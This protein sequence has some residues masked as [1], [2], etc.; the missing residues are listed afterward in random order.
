MASTVAMVQAQLQEA[1]AR[2]ELGDVRGLNDK[3]RRCF[4]ALARATHRGELPVLPGG[5][6]HANA[7]PAPP[8]V[9]E[10]EQKQ[11]RGSAEGRLH[12]AHLLE[13]QGL[14]TA[15]RCCL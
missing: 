4:D 11:R 12:A 3:L 2:L 10:L 14:S 15:H 6:A 13:K 9:E 7:A 5:P 8:A 1:R